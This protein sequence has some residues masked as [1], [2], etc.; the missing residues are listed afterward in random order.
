MKAKKKYNTQVESTTDMSKSQSSKGL[1]T[2]FKEN[3]RT[4]DLD[5]GEVATMK[6]RQ[7][8]KVNRGG[9]K[10]TKFRSDFTV[11]DKEGKL[12][13]KQKDRNKRTKLR[14]TRRGKKA[15]Y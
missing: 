10:K 12:L 3:L 15:G 2:K 6:T 13:V 5:N 4:T 8:D 9:K 7:T 11:R 14:V 1:K